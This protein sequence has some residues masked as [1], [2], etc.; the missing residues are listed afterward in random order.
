MDVHFSLLHNLLSVAANEHHWGVVPSPACT[1]CRPPAADE[2]VPHFFTSCERVSATWH[3]LM[4]RATLTLGVGLTDESLLLL[5][6]PATTARA[7]AAV[8][9]AVTTFTAW[10][11]SSRDLPAVLPPHDLRARVLR[12][13]E[14][15]PLASIF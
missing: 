5:T 9:L 2:T 10:A 14:D 8:T 6:W 1:R 7:D 15:G 13:A 3:F 11:W 12:A 4:F